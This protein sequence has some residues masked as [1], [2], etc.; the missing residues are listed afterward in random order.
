MVDCRGLTTID[1]RGLSN[2]ESIGNN[3]MVGCR[4]LTTID[5]TGLSNLKSIGNNFMVNYYNP[6]EIKINKNKVPIL[7]KHNSNQDIRYKY[8]LVIVE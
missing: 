4:G 3:F 1:L 2:L 7:L 5:L 8:K 6:R